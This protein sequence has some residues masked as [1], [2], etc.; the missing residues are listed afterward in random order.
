MAYSSFPG[1]KAVLFDLDG[2]LV[3]SAP[4]LASALNR[5]LAGEGRR[6]VGLGEVKG[7]IGDGV[8][9]L[10]E[11]GFAAAGRALGAGELDQL[12]RRY[13]ADYEPN[14][15]VETRPFPGA[16]EAL[17][18]LKGAG[19]ALGVCT[20]KPEAATREILAAFGMESFF[21]AVVGGDTVP[22]ARKPGPGTMLEA[23]RRLGAG[24]RD[25]IAVGDSPNDV[26]AA[27]AARLPIVAVS[28]GYS[29]IPSG[30]LGADRV[31][32]HFSELGLALAEISAAR[33][34]LTPERSAN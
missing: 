28:F 33:P 27:R 29:P 21:A 14:S 30:E 8:H 1:L 16:I 9:K 5:L 6:A 32:G 3:D 17:A 12:A 7:M 13:V 31:I 11:R 10:V 15:A 18:E 2:T 20:N 23:L 19:L 34:F 26:A 25:A 22:G 24:S 4:D